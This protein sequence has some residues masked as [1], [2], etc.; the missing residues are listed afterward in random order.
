MN[1]TKPE[2]YVHTAIDAI[3]EIYYEGVSKHKP[4]N[5]PPLAKTTWNKLNV[6]QK[7]WLVF[8]VIQTLITVLMS[9]PT[10][11]F[12]FAFVMIIIIVN[13]N[14]LIYGVGLAIAWGLRRLRRSF[15]S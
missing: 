9:L 5:N 4:K 7:V 13:V 10:M 2:D 14:C 1:K 3:D 15:H 11:D 12:G 8:V 6:W